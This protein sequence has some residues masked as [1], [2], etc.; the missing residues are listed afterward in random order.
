MVQDK[1]LIY[2]NCFKG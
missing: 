2:Y 1:L